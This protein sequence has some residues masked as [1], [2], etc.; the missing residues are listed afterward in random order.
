MVRTTAPF[1][2]SL[3]SSSSSSSS[4]PPSCYR[5]GPFSSYRHRR[6][7]LSRPLVSFMVVIVVIVVVFVLIIVVVVVAYQIPFRSFLREP[8]GGGS[9]KLPPGYTGERK[10]L[11]LGVLFRSDSSPCFLSLVPRRNGMGWKVSGG[12]L[13]YF[14]LTLSLGGTNSILSCARG[15]ERGYSVSPEK[16]HRASFRFSFF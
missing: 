11:G 10:K 16:S 9:G 2:F 14:A 13:V 1:S 8:G 12:G 15:S 7:R 4:S 5:I 3:C 6:S